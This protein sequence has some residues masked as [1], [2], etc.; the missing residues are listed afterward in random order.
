MLYLGR[1]RNRWGRR[2]GEKASPIDPTPSCRTVC[3]F[4]FSAAVQLNLLLCEPQKKKKTPKKL[5]ATQAK[6]KGAGQ[7]KGVRIRARVRV[8]LYV[9]FRHIYTAENLQIKP[10]SELLSR[11]GES[12]VGHV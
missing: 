5:P 3:C 4:D 9:K 12:L 10:G 2:R 1:N 7:L 8:T 6:E 11:E